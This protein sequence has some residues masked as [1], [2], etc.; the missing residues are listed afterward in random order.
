MFT[1]ARTTDN[2]FAEN[3][4]RRDGR[5]NR[6]RYF[7]RNLVI[8][9]ASTIIITV[10]A[11]MDVN[12]LGML[13][14]FG[15]VL[16]KMIYAAAQVPV[17]CLMIRRLHDMDKPETIAYVYV[18]LNLVE[19]ISLGNDFLVTEPS[20][21]ENA[22][23]LVVGIIALYVLFCPGIKGDNQYGSDPLE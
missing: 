8:G 4:L 9:F 3:F 12:A 5:L 15:N 17:F 1:I 10:V 18:A 11:L 20:M 7:K 16:I 23:N 19:L 14:S 2:G 21:Y 6:W 13:S 22:N